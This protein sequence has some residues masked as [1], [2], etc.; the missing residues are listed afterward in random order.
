V[1]T[2]ERFT[3]D[4]PKVQPIS[5]PRSCARDEGRSLEVGLQGLASNHLKLL[6]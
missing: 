2:R 6:W 5:A 3:E 4:I 1:A